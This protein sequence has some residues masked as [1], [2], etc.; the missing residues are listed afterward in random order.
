MARKRFVHPDM[1]QDEK[2]LKLSHFSML[3][4]IGLITVAD[5][6][7]RLYAA[8]AALKGQL[9]PED[10]RVTGKTIQAAL[11]EIT[12]TIPAV[13]LYQLDG[14]QYISLKNWEK[15]QAPSHPSPSKIPEPPQNDSGPG[16]DTFVNASR[17][18]Q[19]DFVNHSRPGFGGGEGFGSGL[20]TTTAAGAGE[21]ESPKPEMSPELAAI[22]KTYENEIGPISG[23]IAEELKEI[24][25]RDPPEWF[26]AAVKEAV[27]ANVRKLSY[28]KSILERW[29]KEGFGAGRKGNG[30]SQSGRDT[31]QRRPTGG[32]KA[33]VE[34]WD[35]Y[36]TPDDELARYI[37]GD[38]T[39]AAP[40]AE[41][42]P[43]Q[44]LRGSA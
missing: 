9:F 13:I 26:E 28:I 24:A 22:A 35:K 11:A 14:K 38:G 5:D 43:P 23:I 32:G 7:G 42:E 30:V 2:F 31:G 1:W 15:Y 36:R 19:E 4:F 12:E 21:K 39:S 41:G 44:Q 8:P 16:D 17:N 18:I 3:V 20:L 34:F 37:A 10:R 25:S 33:V 40:I 27:R 6:S 29:R